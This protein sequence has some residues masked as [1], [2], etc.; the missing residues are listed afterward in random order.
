MPSAAQLS[1]IER[2]RTARLQSA[3]SAPLRLPPSQRAPAPAD[4]GPVFGEEGFGDVETRQQRLE[5]RAEPPTPDTAENKGADRIQDVRAQAVQAQADERAAEE[6]QRVATEAQTA[7]GGM[8]AADQLFRDQIDI[9]VNAACYSLP[10]LGHWLW[11]NLRMAYGSWIAGGN[12]RYIGPFGWSDVIMVVLPGG[13]YM[14]AGTAGKAVAQILPDFIAHLVLVFIN[15][16]LMT[17]GA[18]LLAFQIF[19]LYVL[20]LAAT[21]PIGA[22]SQFG[23]LISL[24]L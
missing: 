24:F 5:R 21:D 7:G 15:L 22:M 13:K 10:V 16:L 3:R 12:S 23:G 4:N 20:Y 8:G 17:A 1:T 9:A 6:E 14:G 18:I 2:A 11:W 19:M